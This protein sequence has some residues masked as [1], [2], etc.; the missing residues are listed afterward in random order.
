METETVVVVVVVETE[1]VVVV[2][3]TETV[4]VV[5]ETELLLLLW[6]LKLLL[7]LQEQSS[8][9]L[10]RRFDLKDLIPTAMQRLTK[11]PLLIENLLKYTSCEY[12]H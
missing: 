12:L 10:C 6:R 3:E 2:V 11:Y 4:V 1:T 7:C 8:S 5:V 9:P